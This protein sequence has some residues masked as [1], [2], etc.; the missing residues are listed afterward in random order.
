MYAYVCQIDLGFRY[1]PVLNN[2]KWKK[3]FL[4]PVIIQVHSK[5]P[6]KYDTIANFYHSI[7]HIQLNCISIFGNDPPKSRNY[8]IVSA[9]KDFLM[10]HAQKKQK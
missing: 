8:I 1:S 4:F 6:K 7:I 3:S 5:F 2:E 10:L 9:L